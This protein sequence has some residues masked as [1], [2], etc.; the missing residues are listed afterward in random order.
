MTWALSIILGSVVS[1][2]FILFELKKFWYKEAD[3]KQIYDES[4]L[5]ELRGIKH[6]LERFRADSKENNN[7]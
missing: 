2:V 5:K 7:E 6:E 4:I 3:R 1:I